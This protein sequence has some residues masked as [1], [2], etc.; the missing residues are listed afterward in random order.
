MV[1]YSEVSAGGGERERSGIEGLDN[2]A[3]EDPAFGGFTPE[4]ARARE[5]EIAGKEVPAWK[6]GLRSV[7]DHWARW[8]AA[9]DKAGVGD[10]QR[11]VMQEIFAAEGGVATDGTTVAGITQGTLNDLIEQR[12]LDLPAG[13]EPKDLSYDQMVEFYRAYFAPD[14]GAFGRAAKF[15]TLEAIGN[16]EVAAATA[17]SLVRLGANG[18]VMR[19]VVQHAIAKTLESFPELFEGEGGFV[20]GGKF[21]PRSLVALQGIA[22]SEEARAFHMHA[23]RDARLQYMLTESGSWQKERRVREDGSVEV[24][25]WQGEI[26]RIDRFLFQ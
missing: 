15:E 4:H 10:I 7:T 17:D 12:L 1:P 22:N 3:L 8:A 21:G 2:P 13:I 18:S 9:L 11:F 26:D 25:L 14:G 5:G 19:K 20:V 23:V 24:I 16:R 6:S